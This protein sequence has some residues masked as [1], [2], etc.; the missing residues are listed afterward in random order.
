MAAVVLSVWSCTNE[1]TLGTGLLEEDAAALDQI[2][3]L[4]LLAETVPTEPVRTYVD[5]NEEFLIL[6]QQ[7][8]GE[9]EDPVFGIV[10]AGVYSQLRLNRTS[11]GG[12]AVPDFSG[13]IVL[14]SLVLVLPYAGEAFYGNTAALFGMEVFRL[15]ERMQV[16]ATYFT[17]SSF[18]TLPGALG[19]RSFTPSLDSL[20]VLDYSMGTDT[21]AFPHL[22]VPLDPSLGEEIIQGD[23][24]T[25]SSDSAFQ[26]LLQGVYLQPTTANEGMLGFNLSSSRA[27]L[28]LYYTQNDTLTRQY[29]F[30]TNSVV[31][32]S[33]VEHDYSGSAVEPFLEDSS[34][35]DSLLFVQG[36][37]G[38][39]IRLTFPHIGELQDV[40]VNKAE[41]EFTLAMLPEDD[42]AT[43]A[44][45]DQLI[46]SYR[47]E[48]GELVILDDI[49]FLS[50]E[51][52]FPPE[53]NF[54]QSTLIGTILPSP[55]FGG[56]STQ[57]EGSLIHYRLN[58][59]AH[60]Q[61]M[62]EGAVDNQLV[63]S[64]TP[65]GTSSSRAVFYGSGH[66]DFPARLRLAV[67]KL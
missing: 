25:F 48:E 27:G 65:K 32:T 53:V 12:L 4:T 30:P 60:A 2:D 19:N 21:I 24:L 62:I 14:D 10:T 13:S 28:F 45:P 8:F 22:R 36:G 34:S 7:L 35:E 61:Q 57:G 26:E 54:D 50:R 20:E 11:S 47:E 63:L 1:T 49:R 46:L 38:V 18:Q 59:S 5:P 6:G 66:P 3:T 58:L 31:R 51:V 64:I 29:Q 37:G 9:L 39:N 52:G 23:S 17:S 43:Y 56:Q 55:V 41:L 33:R 16:N 42:P 40:I 67:T 44:P 15:S